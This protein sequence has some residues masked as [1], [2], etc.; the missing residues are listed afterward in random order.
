[1]QGFGDNF[2][3]VTLTD[4]IERIPEKPFRY[5]ETCHED[6]LLIVEVSHHVQDGLLTPDEAADFVRGKVYE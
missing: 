6:E 3:P 1:M 5:D 2:I 4:E